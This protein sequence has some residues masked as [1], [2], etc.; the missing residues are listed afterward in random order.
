MRLLLIQPSDTFINREYESP[1]LGLAYLAAIAEHRGWNVKILVA[2][3]LTAQLSDEY[4]V[5]ESLRFAP[6][7][8]GIRILTFSAKI[9]YKLIKELDCL[10]C[11][12]VAGGHHAT[13]LPDEV[14]THSPCDMVVRGEGEETLN[15]LLA[16]IER[17]ERR[18]SGIKG[19]SFIDEQGRIFHNH[20]RNLLSEENLSKT[21]FPAKHIFSERYFKKSMFGNIIASRGCPYS[22]TFCSQSIFKTSYRIRDVDN[23][24][25]E[26]EELYAT[27][28]VRYI[29][30]ADDIFTVNESWVRALCQKILKCKMHLAWSCSTRVDCVTERLLKEMGE[31][32]CLYIQYGIENINPC[33]SEKIKKKI[34]PDRIKQVLSWTKNS[35]M[36]IVLNFMWG[37]PWETAGDI[38]RQVEFI[39]EVSPL[40]YFT[41]LFGII[42]FPGTELYE[43]YNEKYNFK[44]WWLDRRMQR[45]KLHLYQCIKRYF[46]HQESPFFPLSPAI[47][48]M[49]KKA[50]SVIDDNSIYF[51][52][53]M[54]QIKGKYIIID[55]EKLRRLPSFII[56]RAIKLF[57][58]NFSKVV[59]SFS[60]ELDLKLLVPFYRIIRKLYGYFM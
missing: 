10:N 11:V 5:R 3:T 43:K 28:K 59:S 9:S 17:G 24:F 33:V 31:A 34:E 32:G 16:L 56:I 55:R 35:G 49:I 13:I 50:C 47:R 19:I 39:I 29:Y 25:A 15:E 23:V 20:D 46:P 36:G 12:I 38:K 26:I 41:D 40:T 45:R 14:L 48:T 60:P 21:P 18:P 6:D 42:P 27:Y 44:E 7:V 57:F 22:C 2:S 52:S 54:R 30:F 4:I 53:M 58:A 1:P 8:I 51:Y 37:F